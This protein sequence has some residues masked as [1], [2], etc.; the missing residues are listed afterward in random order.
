MKGKKLID[1]SISFFFTLIAEGFEAHLLKTFP[2]F[3]R[4]RDEIL[5]ELNLKAKVGTMWDEKRKSCQS[6][7]SSSYKRKTYRHRK[8]KNISFFSWLTLEMVNCDSPSRWLLSLSLSLSPA[9]RQVLFLS[10]A[11]SSAGTDKASSGMESSPK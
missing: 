7:F 3:S 8:E 5:K 11:Y 2:L 9:H 4:C 10:R 1:F 6:L